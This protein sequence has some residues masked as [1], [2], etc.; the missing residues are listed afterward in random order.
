MVVI[1]VIMILLF[2]INI[3]GTIVLIKDKLKLS[4]IAGVLLLLGIPVLILASVIFI[5]T[6]PAGLILTV[7]YFI[8]VYIS[9][10]YVSIFIGVL[11]LKRQFND[12]QTFFLPMI[13]GLIIISIL[14]NVPFFNIFIS[15]V[16]YVLGMGGIAIYFYSL[17]QKQNEM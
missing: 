13:L 16:I 11:L 10:I 5:I 7:I 2:K 17:Y 4:F 9:K 3:L 1:G 8:A 12:E 6:I 15:P 14:T